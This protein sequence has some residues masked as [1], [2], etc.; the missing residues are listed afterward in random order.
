[1]TDLP[2][3]QPDSRTDTV[4]AAPDRM[5]RVREAFGIDNDMEVPAFSESDDL[6]RAVFLSPTAELWV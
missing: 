1:M 5:V 6:R 4:L 3:V 2:N